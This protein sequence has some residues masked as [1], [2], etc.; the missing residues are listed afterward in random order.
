[1][2]IVY[3]SNS[4]IPSRAAN[5]IHVMKMCQ[6]F[7]SN[8]HEVVL[9]APCHKNNIT[10]IDLYA[11]YGV[12]ES[13][14]IKF[15]PFLNLPKIWLFS[16][17]YN[18]YKFINKS[19]FDIAY[20]RDLKSCFL[21][22]KSISNLEV[23]YEAHKPFEKHNIIDKMVFKSIVKRDEFNKLVVISHALRNMYFNLSIFSSCKI[24]VAHDGADI[25]IK[26]N[27]I[28]S[29]CSSNEKLKIGYTG[30]LY[31]GRGVEVILELAKRLSN[32]E[33]HIVGGVPEDIEYW[34]CQLNSNNVTF[35]GFVEPSEVCKYINS[36]DILLAPY[37]NKVT[38]MGG[39]GD[40]SKYMSP[41]K[42]FEYMANKK[43]IIV[44][45]ISVLREILS[46]SEALF[47]DC[48]N[49]NEWVSAIKSLKDI[50]ERERI[51]QK[52]FNKLS[53]HY[54]WSVRAKKIL[55]FL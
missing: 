31:D 47:V 9:L 48:T 33:F 1:M 16:Y 53:A 19:N 25:P 54:T 23:I 21:A 3:I 27:K 35:H 50:H 30:H 8:G 44:S 40:T 28:E 52:A 34:K 14:I 11:Y 4:K 38:L 20:G 45:D 26:N 29:I 5:S 2:R 32:M 42:I 43:P 37:Q 12:S 22:T 15:V 41:L 18:V 36:F 51:S 13:F 55:E 46:P 49:I 17:A 39:K 6:A 10:N 24:D 7:A